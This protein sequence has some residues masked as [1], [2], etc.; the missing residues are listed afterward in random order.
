MVTKV[1]FVSFSDCCYFFNRS[2]IDRL[3]INEG[4]EQGSQLDYI[5]TARQLGYG[6]IVTNTNMKTDESSP[7]STGLIRVS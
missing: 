1:E 3:I 6:V 4:L 7:H 2:F 5:K